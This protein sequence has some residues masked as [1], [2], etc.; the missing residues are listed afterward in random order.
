M[1]QNKKLSQKS[2]KRWLE[3]KEAKKEAE[4]KEDKEKVKKTL[5]Y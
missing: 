3:I 2:G 1:N 5:N 4:I